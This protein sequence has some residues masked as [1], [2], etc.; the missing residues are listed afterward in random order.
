MHSTRLNLAAQKCLE[1]KTSKKPKTHGYSRMLE[2]VLHFFI[3]A[4][5]QE[6]FEN[7]R[8]SAYLFQ[9]LLCEAPG[10]LMPLEV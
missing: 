6:Y 2:L 9:I 3:C 8:N 7:P 10:T 4:L 1:P 5:I